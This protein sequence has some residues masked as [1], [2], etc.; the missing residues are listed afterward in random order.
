[1]DL[2]FQARLRKGD[3]FTATDVDIRFLDGFNCC[4]RL[5][6]NL[7]LVSPRTMTFHM[8]VQYTQKGFIL[9]LALWVIAAAGLA[10]A[11]LSEWVSQA[12]NNAQILQDRVEVEIAFAD[13]RNE[14]VF[15]LAR[16][17]YTYRGLQV[18]EFN[19]PIMGTTFDDVI[20]VDLTSD[21]M[22]FL[23]GRP[24]ITASNE[25]FV[26]KIQDG[27]GLINLNT[28][29]DQ[30]FE[31][32]FNSLNVSEDSTDQLTDSFMDYRDPDDFTRLSGAEEQDYVRRGLYPPSN[33]QLITPWEAQRIIGWT[34]LKQ[35]WDA[36]Y[37][38]PVV[39]TCRSSGFN[40]NTAP[41]NVLATY[42]RGV[43]PE[44][45]ELVKSYRETLPFRN[46]RE[47]GDSAG[48][49]LANQPFFFSFIP[50]RC[51]LVDLI[52]LQT[53]ERIRFSLTLLPRNPA[54]PWQIDYVLR[55][56]KEYKR[57]LSRLDPELRFPS[58]EEISGRRG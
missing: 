46:A 40:P 27:R 48:V 30:Y 43:T 32:L 10:A 54:Q 23:D 24:Y 12:V 14:L 2:Y 41:A 3:S 1:M 56:P 51:L 26:V 13:I 19:T 53:E 52:D 29:N 35:L 38:T 50:G 58:P 57:A 6:A 33:S 49:I 45:A 15:A 36:Q 31:V 20:N 17:P 7:V 42:L 39:T 55:I 28:I 22:I 47:L 4:Q 9:P 8:V 34:R 5:T 37:E 25:R 18:G 21:R 44:R 11:V 16:R